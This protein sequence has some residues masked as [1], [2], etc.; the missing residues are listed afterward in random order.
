MAAFSCQSSFL[1]QCSSRRRIEHELHSAGIRATKSSKIG[2]LSQDHDK[3]LSLANPIVDINARP[4]VKQF[5]QNIPKKRQ[6]S[7]PYRLGMLVDGGVEY[8]QTLVVRSNEVGPDQNMTLDSL[9]HLFQETALNHV[10]NSGEMKEYGTTHGMVKHNLI[11]VI[12]RMIVQIDHY[13]I[14]GEVIEIDTWVGASGKHGM[15]RDW[16]LRSKATGIILVR[17]TSTF[18]MMNKHTRRLSKIPEDAREELTQWFTEKQAV[19]ESYTEIRKL[20]DNACKFNIELKPKR[21]DLDMNHHVNYAKYAKWMIETVPEEFL[22]N[23]QL[24]QIALE[25]R[26][27]CGTSDIVQS[28]CEPHEHG[29]P[30]GNRA[31]QT[32]YTHLLRIKGDHKYDELVRGKTTWKYKHE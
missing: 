6:L 24:A 12:S 11:W 1:F 26:R 9:L 2:I 19:E 20:N 21:C 23:H 30:N 4:L 17:A 32:T 27:E 29:G 22:E 25:Y 13:P 7:D 3:A 18:V 8:R 31:L 15:S 14:W 10:W 28:L 16:L 5:R